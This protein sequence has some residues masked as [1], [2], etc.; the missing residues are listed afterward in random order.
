MNHS[1]LL[2]QEIETTR[3]E[4]KTDSYSMSIGELRS[5]YESEELIINPDFQR[6]YR[7]TDVQKT[8][9]IESILLGI[10]IP[11][12]F[13]YQ[14]KDGVWELVD[15]LQRVSTILQFMGVL[16]NKDGELYPPL[17]LK[18]TKHLPHF[19]GIYWENPPEGKTEIPAS[20]R[21]FIKRSKLKFSIILSDSGDYAKF[22]V[23]Q[24]LN[25]GGTFASNQEV[26]NAMTIMANKDVATW[27]N[28]LA[29]HP[30]FLQI[31][32]ITDRLIEEQYNVELVLRYIGLRFLEY[33]SNYD[34][35]DFLDEAL[36]YVLSKDENWRTEIGAEFKK[37]FDLLASTG[38]KVLK[39]YDG[40]N[41]K[42]K[43]LESAFEAITIGL[44]YNSDE[45]TTEDTDFILNKIYSLWSED[46]FLSA[47]GSG[48]NASYRIPRV[49]P[50]A[51]SFFKK[52]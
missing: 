51:K 17:E 6:Y 14:R 43:F 35:K 30:S 18:K 39:K 42:G 45:Y 7:W 22:E 48:S 1:E 26:R 19:A 31:I 12:L 37:V 25:T 52:S 33:F 3:T 5:M 20:L 15:G 8:N 46:V 24:R 21:L 36:D 13:V 2:L 9:L 38:C 23:F 49:V 40:E 27:F 4:F 11:S 41:F 50:F 47:S 44:G 32:S 16:K 10:P 28:E 29:V 34:V